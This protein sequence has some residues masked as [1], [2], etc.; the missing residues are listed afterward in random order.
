MVV[1]RIPCG[2]SLDWSHNWRLVDMTLKAIPPVQGI[3]STNACPIILGLLYWN[4]SHFTPFCLIKLAMQ[5]C[6]GAWVF[7]DNSICISVR[8]NSQQ[9]TYWLT[10]FRFES[11]I[12]SVKGRETGH[13]SSPDLMPSIGFPWEV[14]AGE[15]RYELPECPVWF[16]PTQALV[17]FA[18]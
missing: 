16:G 14:D 12:L 7:T 9:L 17:V 3:K 5:P 4:F 2:P 18:V 8:R 11:E 15:T 10:A 13:L 1:F 6:S